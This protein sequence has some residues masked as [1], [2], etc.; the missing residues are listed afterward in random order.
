MQRV[1]SAVGIAVIGSVF[2]G[3]LTVTGP[4]ADALATAFT[5]SATMAMAV[6]AGF[7]ILALV[8]VFALPKR[9]DGT[10]PA[11]AG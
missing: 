3:T 9:V 10:G 5:H 6:S 1:G 8:L 4:G 11:A 7:A 2:F